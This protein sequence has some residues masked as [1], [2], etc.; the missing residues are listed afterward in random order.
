[1]VSAFHTGPRPRALL[2]SPHRDRPDLARI[3]ESLGFAPRLE[4]SLSAGLAACGTG[5]DRVVL[6]ERESWNRAEAE[7]T[8]AALR[9]ASTRMLPVLLVTPEVRHACF[10]GLGPEVLV[11][12]PWFSD[13]RV[14]LSIG[15]A[16]LRRGMSGASGDPP[17]VDQKWLDILGR[18][19][20][21]Q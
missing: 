5:E 21:P 18:I 16:F 13:R 11:L 4:P 19:V 12:S 2:H 8:L 14:A 7:D 20:D 9:A 17:V 15:A 10:L 3:L 1:M 6:L